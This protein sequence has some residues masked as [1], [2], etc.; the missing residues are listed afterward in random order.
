MS[1]FKALLSGKS[2][3][4]ANTERE[5]RIF[6]WPGARFDA[7]LLIQSLIMVGMQ[8]ALLKIALDHRPAPSN[9]GGEAGLP[10]APPEGVFTQRPYNFW[11]WRSPKP[12]SLTKEETSA[13]KYRK[14]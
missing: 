9:K 12:L 5:N 13:W 4:T 7:S 14:G 6:Y 2:G 8:V 1:Q 10:F 3:A 11:Q